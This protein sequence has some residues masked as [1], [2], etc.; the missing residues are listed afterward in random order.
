[1][2]E[3]WS[4]HIFPSMR[5]AWPTEWMSTLKAVAKIDANILVP[6]HGFIEDPRVMKDEFAQFSKALDY[7]VAEATRLH[8][9]GVTF[10]EALKQADWG[11]TSSGL[12]RTGMPQSPCSAFTTNWM[13]S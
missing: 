12:A 7:V 8:K 2:S 10:E 6:G 11:R 4:N 1:M 9:T 13:E 5:T 3:V